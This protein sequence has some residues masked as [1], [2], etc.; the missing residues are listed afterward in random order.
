MQFLKNIFRRLSDVRL[1]KQLILTFSVIL[2]VNIVIGIYFTTKIGG[3]KTLVEV[4]Y[5]NP[6]MSS[7]FAMSAKYRFERADSLVRTAIFI[8]DKEKI[9]ALKKEINS[10][11]EQGDEDL[12]VVQER[13][14]AESSKEL[15]E[16]VLSKVNEYKE[17]IDTTLAAAEENL[18]VKDSS[19]DIL[20]LEQY[21]AKDNRTFIQK[22]LTE[23]TDDAAE[24]GYTFRLDSEARNAETV[25]FFYFGSTATV[26][27]TLL[28]AYFLSRTIAK[29]LS[30]YSKTC[31]EISDGNYKKRVNV[32]GSESEIAVLGKSFNLMLDRV[33]EKDRNMK[34]LLD[35][36]TTAVFSF[37]KDGIISSEK[38]IACNYIFQ[39]YEL[40]NIYS[41][42]NHH[43]GLAKQGLE[44]SLQ[45]LWDPTIDMDF[46]SLTSG[47][48]PNKMTLPYG[49]KN[50]TKYI[51][52]RYKQNLNSHQK[53]EKIIVLADDIT[54]TTLAQ[55]NAVIQAE[56]VERISKASLGAENY[57]ESRNSFISLIQNSQH[58]LT[59]GASKLTKTETADLKRQL[60]SL[61]GE[62]AIMGHK[63]CA[64]QVHHIESSLT[65]ELNAS[66]DTTLLENIKKIDA[67]FSLESAD[68][69][70]VLGLDS[71][72]KSIKVDLEK[73]T[74]LRNFV[75]QSEHLSAEQKLSLKSKLNTLV[76]KPMQQFFQKYDEYCKVLSENLGKSVNL[77]F[78]SR[79][80]EV[81]YEEVSRLDAIF[82]H[83]LRN[84]LDHG[85]EEMEL[86]EELGKPDTGSITISAAR[87]PDLKVLEISIQDDGRGI[88]HKR[89]IDKAVAKGLWTAEKAKAASKEEALDLIFLSDFS[90][91]EVVTE[92]S[93][94]G[95]GMDAVRSEVVGLGGS[96]TLQT[97]IG[98]GTQFTIRLPL[99]T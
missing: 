42:F 53:L 12:A 8:K 52:L 48:F 60:H 70:S 26:L 51:S 81:A 82:G 56:R 46:D 45:L 25:K 34:S 31:I 76:Q 71:Q 65:A 16:L 22:K 74:A 79:S 23:L 90:T 49:D 91:K 68:V 21:L 61:K 85:I 18:K 39:D 36:L 9:K 20:L 5:D 99:I 75:V 98:K 32:F 13:A 59:K 24:T 80:D 63:T 10:Q 55:K 77:I 11:V 84:S 96:L 66:I 35:G 2:I 4:M 92:T 73:I 88:D 57:I 97:D 29:P 89:L 72:S 37:D 87:K 27:I 64:S 30:D 3:L 6:L 93:G 58:I 1:L 7:T 62:L 43:N 47:V 40:N 50:P 17:V 28:L 94:R 19:V 33:D 15:A 83:L 69:L 14:I 86:R 44:E 95:V 41:F 78:D 67:E 38:S 54:E